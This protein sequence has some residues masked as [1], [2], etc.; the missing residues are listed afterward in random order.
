MHIL[1]LNSFHG[2]SAACLLTDGRIVAAAEEE[3][4]TRVK[5]WAGFPETAIRYC[6]EEAGLR[7]EDVDR[8]AVNHDSSANLWPRLAYVVRSRPRPGAILDR[9]RRRRRRA[10]LASHF[11]RAFG[12]GRLRAAV[13]GVEH[14]ASHLASAFFGSRFAESLALS[15]DGFGDFASTAWGI[16]RGTSVEITQRVLYPH[17][18]GIFYQGLTQYLGFPDY[19]DEFKVMGLAP[20]GEPRHVEPM[21]RLV[22]LENNGGFRLD[23]AHFR[24]A[25][26]DLE[27]MWSAGAPRFE[28]LFS[29]ALE[30][31]LGPARA[32]G[33]PITQRHRDLASS[34]QAVYEETFFHLLRHAHAGLGMASL[35]LAGGCA[36]NSVANGKITRET[37]IRH[38]YVQPASGDAGGAA[39]AAMAAWARLAGTRPQPM[40]HAYLGPAFGD[41]QYA[42]CLEA[43]SAELRGQSCTQE[44]LVDE[45]ALCR[46]VAGLIAGGRVVGWFQGRMEWGPR[47]LGNRSILGDPRRN[48]MKELLNAK[49]KRRESFRPFAPSILREAVADWFT[50]DD[51]VPF[52]THVYPVRAERQALIPAVTHVDGSG[53]IH[54]VSA[55]GNPRFHRL[56]TAFQGLTGVPMLLNTSFNESEPI[57]CTPAQ[58]LDCFVRTRMDCLVLGDRVLLRPTA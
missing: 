57:V 7:L 9:L 21:R 33:E 46:K 41:E 29:P 27:L 25:G 15:V 16:G 26:G 22:T 18:L 12:T 45:D 14:H 31:L 5:H 37:S 58:A 43:R 11:E 19:G 3:R 20:Y 54:T 35:V 38:T 13:E 23:L 39:G 48:D 17:S 28:P 51:D 1:G 53:R 24:H 4:F 47:A 6:L 2:D 56:I 55:Q 40:D 50:I 42:A 49:I 32:P 36:Q 10:D 8:V 52:M 30:D 44:R 34:V